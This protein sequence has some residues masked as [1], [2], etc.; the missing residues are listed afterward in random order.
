M[1]YIPTEVVDNI[2]SH[3]E[4]DDFNTL[5]QCALVNRQ[6]ARSALRALYRSE[7]L[8]PGV[9]RSSAYEHS[10]IAKRA[11]QW[12]KFW[13][14]LIISALTFN[15]YLPYA[16]FLHTL[17]LCDL[18]LLI[19]IDRDFAE[20][21][22]YGEFGFKLKLICFEN[23]CNICAAVG[24]VILEVNSGITSLVCDSCPETWDSEIERNRYLGVSAS[25]LDWWAPHLTRL[26]TLWYN[27]GKHLSVENA[28]SIAHHCPRFRNLIVWEWME[29]TMSSARFASDDSDSDTEEE[30]ASAGD[31][32]L[33]LR[34]NAL[35]RFEVTRD[36][37]FNPS[38]ITGL[39]A[40]L[41]SLRVLRVPKLR[42]QLV[43]ELLK[44]DPL[45]SLESIHFFLSSER[46]VALVPSFGRW[47]GACRNLRRIETW[48]YHDELL[49]LA[50]ALNHGILSLEVLI[51]QQNYED[52]TRIIDAFYRGLSR[53]H[54]LQELTLN[55]E[56]T[57]QKSIFMWCLFPLKKLRKLNLRKMSNQLT[58]TEIRTLSGS[59]PNLTWLGLYVTPV[60][61]EIWDCI[62]APKLRYL[63]L[64]GIGYLHAEPAINFILRLGEQN[65]GFILKLKFTT[66]AEDNTTV[67]EGDHLLISF[68]LRRH[69]NGHLLPY[70]EML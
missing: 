3:V 55:T 33:S 61:D 60:V 6:F 46:C 40:H 48:L 51:V 2:M 70:R 54:N 32:L 66:F 38:M 63:H 19:H 8:F 69:L 59:F 68:V 17:D 16:Q 23:Y 22:R 21:L 26:E 65:R 34:H 27:L 4:P 36:S 7:A 37:Y 64:V 53:Q 39:T 31:F 41:Q 58:L 11:K 10:L 13:W 25:V 20:K 43:T 24:W 50:N 49:L 57:S 52:N 47:L 5:F 15:T 42:P 67:S 35:E 12:S 1:V 28:Y 14:I 29:F 9:K 56:M 30:Q 62:V 45:P 44:L 18:A